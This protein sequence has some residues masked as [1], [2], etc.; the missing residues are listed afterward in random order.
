MRVVPPVV[1]T[2]R[3]HRRSPDMGWPQA[4]GGR[5]TRSFCQREP[6]CSSV[7]F[8]ALMSAFSIRATLRWR[9]TARKL[10]LPFATSS[11]RAPLAIQRHVM[12]QRAFLVQWTG[13]VSVKQVLAGVAGDFLGGR[14]GNAGINHF[15]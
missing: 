14:A 12:R 13:K 1:V 8:Q 2:V 9:R 6:K 11:I 7:T 3:F 10:R 15:L 4:C 5:T